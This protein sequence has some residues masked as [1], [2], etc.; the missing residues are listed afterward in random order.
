VRDEIALDIVDEVDTV[1][2]L[3]GA[4]GGDGIV[5]NGVVLCI[6]HQP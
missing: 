3:G 1:V 4:S 2:E 6:A 5:F